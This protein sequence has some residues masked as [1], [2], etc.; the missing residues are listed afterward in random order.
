MELSKINHNDLILEIG[1]GNGNLTKILRQHCRYLISVEIDRNLYDD[2]KEMLKYDNLLFLNCDILFKKQLNPLVLEV[3]ESKKDL[4][5]KIVSNPPYNI[6]SPLLEAVVSSPITFKD[7][8][9]TVQKE[10]A[11]R[12]VADVGSSNYSSL[13]VFIQSFCEVKILRLISKQCFFPMPQ[14]DS[15]FVHIKPIYKVSEKYRNYSKFLKKV[16]SQRR[17]NI[18]N[19]FLNIFNGDTVNDILRKFDINVNLR[20]ENIK[21]TVFKQIYENYY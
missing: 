19:V 14:V 2:V 7:I 11:E 21:P 10:I 8:F 18:K 6:I 17:K 20:C 13:S 3:I 12:L 5:P 4:T 16:F 9:L 15:A 1:T